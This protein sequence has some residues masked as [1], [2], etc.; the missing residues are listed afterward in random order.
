M[1]ILLLWGKKKGEKAPDPPQP[2]LRAMF[3]EGFL[4]LFFFCFVLFF[5]FNQVKVPT[6][7]RKH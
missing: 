6:S 3:G 7:W 2:P 1:T 5:F 4:S